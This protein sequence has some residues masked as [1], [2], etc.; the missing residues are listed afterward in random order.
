MPT[1]AGYD[2][3][4]AQIGS[5]GG[6]PGEGAGSLGLLDGQSKNGKAQGF[7]FEQPVQIQVGDR[8]TTAHCF[9]P[10]KAGGVPVF[11]D[12]FEG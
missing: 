12:R 9:F 2:R 8:G 3:G 1:L 4:D 10:S 5:R 7:E 6:Y 11:L